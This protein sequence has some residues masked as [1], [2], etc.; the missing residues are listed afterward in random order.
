VKPNTY[1]RR[2]ILRQSAAAGAGAAL[3]ATAATANARVAAALPAL[4]EEQVNVTYTNYSSGQD[5]PLWDGMIATFQEQNPNITVT[6]EPIPGASWGEYF[7]KVATLIAGGNPPDVVRVAIEGTLLFV[8]RELPIALDDY[9][10]G[11][12]EIEEFLG[13][14]N[15][16]LIDP[17][18]ID[19]QTWQ[20]PFDW[21]NMVMFYNTAMFEAE[22]LETPAP[23][24]TWEQWLETARAL[25]KDGVYGF[26]T[27]VQYFAGVMPWIFNAGGNLLSDDWTTSQVNSPEVLE[28]VSFMRS[29]IW[30]EEVAP[31]APASHDDIL[32]LAASG[33][34][35]M[36]GGGRWPTLTLTNAGF[37]D[38]D[39]QF[40]PMQA[41]QIT[42]FGVGGFP[43]LRSSPVPDEAWTWVKYLTTPE[44][45]EVITRL[46][47]SIP[48]RRSLAES[49][50]MFALPPANAGIYYASVD[51]REAKPVPSPARYNEV[52]SV[53]RRYLGQILA[54]E[55]S[56]EDGLAAADA[57]VVTILAS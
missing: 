11:D 49:D 33:S 24:W 2:D 12:P 6:Y 20:L 16:Q 9:M 32:N 27:A 54:N 22:G 15:Q 36:W 39:V 45:F 13:D 41:T 40:W 18:V 55:I 7:D 1:S 56:P 51:D 28:A 29:L 48:A 37:S 3:V 31:S 23:D 44:A 43:I 57:E 25:T 5:K 21:N 38:F 42:E 34:L 17:F 35:G 4:Q 50:A 52:E 10:A 30:D 14:V 26:G 47:Q 53:V 8:S 19:G 46:G